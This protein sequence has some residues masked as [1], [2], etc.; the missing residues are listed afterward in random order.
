M[1]EINQKV[2]ALRTIISDAQHMIYHIQDEE[3]T[4]QKGV[5]KYFSS[6]GDWDNYNRYWRV[7]KCGECGK[8]WSED[9]STVYE[10]N[11]CTHVEIRNEKYYQT[12]AGW[13]EGEV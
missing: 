6:C 4:H 3:C 9:D 13:V 11:D 7:F 5:Y 8:K 2:S 1:L 10:N 12:I